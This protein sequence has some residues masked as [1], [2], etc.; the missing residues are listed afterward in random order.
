M[1]K[2]KGVNIAFETTLFAPQRKLNLVI[3]YVDYWII[4]L[5]FQYD[6]VINDEIEKVDIN[7]LLQNHRLLKSGEEDSVIEYR[8]VIMKEMLKNSSNMIIKLKQ[9][10]IKRLSLLQYHSLAKNKYIRLG[11]RI[12]IFVP[13]TNEDFDNLISDLNLN[14]IKVGEILKIQ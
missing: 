6:Y 1:L 3:D 2:L 9:L 10:G 7:D 12:R 4:D 14:G 11:K 8:M 5:K 13:P